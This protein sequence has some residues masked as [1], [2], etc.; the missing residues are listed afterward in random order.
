MDTA[1]TATSR[2]SI[3]KSASGIPCIG[4]GSY[5]IRGQS[6]AAAVLA[7]LS[8]GYRHI[9]SAALYRNEVRVREAIEQSGVARQDLFL[10][11][12][13]GSP[14][15]KTEKTEVYEDVL[16]TVERIAGKDGYVDLLLMHVP[17]TSREHR[18]S[19]WG[20]M[21]RI[22]REARARYVG[23]SNF[24]V[25]HID[26]MKE[27]ATEWPPS[28]NQIELH[29]WCQQKEVV[30]YCQDNDIIIEAY[31][32]L[33][34]G[35]RL[36]DPVVESISTKHDKSHAQIL[37]RYSLQKGWIPLPKSSR[38]DRISKNFDVFDFVL[39]RDDMETLDGLDKGPAGA[40]F[41][42]NVD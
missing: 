24:R 32:P 41:K 23:V 19:L 18:Q 4:F 17:G 9:D 14:R 15:R 28:V 13:V 20:A 35:A 30:K 5:R 8:A 12:K 26:E 37:I 11:T 31:S 40:V 16:A 36:N 38:P 21:E 22:K 2:L 10:T 3:Q 39:D 42:M 27:Y 34:T 7:A 25:R 1:L 6:C 33:A 29:P